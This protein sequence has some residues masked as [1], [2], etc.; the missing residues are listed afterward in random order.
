MQRTLATGTDFLGIARQSH[1]Q[2]QA[3]RR[4]HIFHSS[5]KRRASTIAALEEDDNRKTV[6][7]SQSGNSA[8][9]RIMSSQEFNRRMTRSKAPAFDP[10]AASF[11][12]APDVRIPPPGWQPQPEQIFRGG[13]I[14]AKMRHAAG[15]VAQ[16]QLGHYPVSYNTLQNSSL[17]AT[18]KHAS[19]GQSRP[20]GTPSPHANPAHDPEVS[21]DGESGPS[22]GVPEPQSRPRQ[23]S[24]V[25]I[26]IL[27]KEAEAGKPV[28]ISKK[29]RKYLV[30]SAESGGVPDPS[31]KYRSQS[32]RPP[33]RLLVPRRILVVIDLNGTLLHRPNH[34]KSASFVERPFA[35]V[36]LDYCLRTFVV[37]IWSSAKPENVRRM[38]PQILSP[39]DQSLLVATWGRDTLGLS[40]DDYNQRVQC[41]KRLEVL[42]NDSK[43]AA[44]HPEAHLGFKWDQTN[45]VLIDDSKEKA[46]S[47]PYNLIQLPEFEGDTNEAGFVL[48]QVHDYLNECAQ[49]RDISCYIRERPFQFNPD[50]QLDLTG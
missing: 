28:K 22:V 40:P 20:T 49:Q 31:K 11:M 25:E 46:R 41:Y 24:T 8:E 17:A 23:V 36:F 48:P 37:A 43:V 3:F 10:A 18:N 45:T 14:P 34:K 6:A 44:S 1:W 15:H 30:P 21:S 5:L 7:G 47:Q 42:W 13:Q 33:A 32:A 50:F 12:P 39:Q 19:Q 29:K 16:G 4:K 27:G 26:P 9:I 35:R 38:V 2:H